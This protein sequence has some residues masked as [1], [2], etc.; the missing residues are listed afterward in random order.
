M[1]R[2]H[3]SEY[4]TFIMG[5]FNSDIST[6]NSYHSS[7]KQFM[8]M[9]DLKPIIT[10]FTRICKTSSTVKVLVLISDVSKVS[11][12]GVI[13]TSFSDHFMTYC[14]RK[15]TNPFIGKQLLL[16]VRSMKTYT[17]KNFQFSLL[18]TEWK[19]VLLSDNVNEAWY[20]LKTILSYSICLL[21]QCN[22]V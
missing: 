20:N 2:T 9:F 18:S 5:D 11:Q 12:S 17:K 21:I 3:F 7:L 16:T 1:N 13:H 15:I 22:S 14:T 10:D 19:S 8:N 4:E 6:T